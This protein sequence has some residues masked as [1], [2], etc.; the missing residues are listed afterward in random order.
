[1]LFTQ[2]ENWGQTPIAPRDEIHAARADRAEKS[3][4]AI[5]HALRNNAEKPTSTGFRDMVDG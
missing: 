3:P 2:K 1:M 5:G 4:R